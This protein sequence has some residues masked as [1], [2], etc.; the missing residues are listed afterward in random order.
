MLVL[1]GYRQCSKED[2]GCHNYS[3]SS[4]GIS[5]VIGSLPLVVV[6]VALYF[7]KPVF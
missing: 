2:V 7:C 3:R 5:F 4:R 6:V 1:I